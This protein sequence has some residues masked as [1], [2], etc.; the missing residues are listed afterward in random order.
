ML[1]N[2][3]R[4]ANSDYL[5]FID[6]DCV[7]S[8][9]FLLD[10][11]EQRR[12]RVVL[13]GRRVE[14]SRRWT[15]ALTLDDVLTGRFERLGW[16]EVLDGLR[17]KSLRVEDGLRIGSPLVRRLLLRRVRGLLGSNFSVGRRELIEVNG[18]DELYDG[19]G[20]GEDSDLQYRLSLIG[21]TGKSIRNLAILYHLHHA[22]M[23][24]SDPSWDRFQRVKNSREPR[25]L[26]GL[27]Y[28]EG[29]PL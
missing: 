27:V 14:T 3:I 21:V 5:V 12:T 26:Q 28:L 6:G 8:R 10:H 29:K 19:P 11:W 15:E 4:T 24:V 17:G 9:H 16:P 18:F 7:P 25:C 23:P 20:C 22:P 2:A 13:L 1:N